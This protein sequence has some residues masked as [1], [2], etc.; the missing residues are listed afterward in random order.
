LSLLAVKFNASKLMQG[1][2]LISIIWTLITIW[3]WLLSSNG[4][5]TYPRHNTM[6]LL[7]AGCCEF[8]NNVAHKWRF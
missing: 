3:W 2:L 4:H 1:T 5:W 8:G 7:F 6:F